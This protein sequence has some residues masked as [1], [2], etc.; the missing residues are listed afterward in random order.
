MAASFG[1][2]LRGEVNP[3]N[4]IPGVADIVEILEGGEVE[5]ADLSVLT[6]AVNKMTKLASGK[7]AITD[8]TSGWKA[9][10]DVGGSIAKLFGVPVKNVMRELR[11]VYNVFTQ[12]ARA[13]DPTVF[14]L[15][16]AE[17]LHV[18][19]D[20]F[21]GFTLVDTSTQAYVERMYKALRAGDE[22]AA[23]DYREYLIDGKGVKEGSIKSKVKSLLYADYASEQIG[24]DDAIQFGMDQELWKKE[25]DAYSALIQAA[26]KADHTGEDEYKTSAYVKIYDAL[27]AGDKAAYNAAVKDMASHG[28]TDKA[29]QSEAKSQIGKWYK[30][31][32]LSQAQA[33]SMLA[34]LGITAKNDVYWT[35]DA[36]DYQ[37][38]N[39]DSTGYTKYDDFLEA[40]ETGKGLQA[41]IQ[42]QIQHSDRTEKEVKSTLASQITSKYKDQYVQLVRAGRTGEA[43]NLQARLLTA[44]EALGYNR[45]KKLKDIQKW[46]K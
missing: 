44:Y 45:A 13:T 30:D 38:E 16:L 23:A 46:L 5:R 26:D 31:G 17:G 35:L 36:W 39:G 29:V 3:F 2:N 15:S 41:A 9:V 20:K 14:R 37:A 42:A 18:L 21:L 40:V 22:K 34:M 1:Q 25:K 12:P 19:P 32:E 10:E 4:L 24:I 27:L 28:Y 7:Y 33:T 6:D 8:F 11:T 43:A